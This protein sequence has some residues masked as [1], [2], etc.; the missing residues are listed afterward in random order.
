MTDLNELED[1]YITSDTWFGRE[2]ILDIANRR[3]WSNVSEMNQA[4]I[5][6]WNKSIKKNDVVLHLGNFSW[7][8]ETA[9]TILSKLNGTILFMQGSSDDAL[10]EVYQEFNNL[11]ILPN[12]ITILP[13]HDLVLC[14]YP[15]SM[16]PGKDSG[17]IHM[18][19]HAIYSHKTNLSIEH[20]FNMCTDYWGYSPIKLSTLKDIL[21]ESKN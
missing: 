12:D 7:D 18:H 3:S 13:N 11:Y 1:F 10:L 5:K 9:R 21:N 15:L 4:L 17:T 14:H 2:Q 16:W 8:P 19:G 6:S 20:R